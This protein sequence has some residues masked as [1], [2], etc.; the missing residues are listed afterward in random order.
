MCFLILHDTSC[1]YVRMS[2][3]II[4]CLLLCSHHM[5]MMA[6]EKAHMNA[7]INHFA[8]FGICSFISNKKVEQRISGSSWSLCPSFPYDMTIVNICQPI[9]LSLSIP[10]NHCWDFC[11]CRL[12]LSYP[13]IQIIKPGSLRDCVHASPTSSLLSLSLDLHFKYTHL[14]CTFSRLVVWFYV[15]LHILQH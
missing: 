1:A 8:P 5:G 14:Q 7:Q 15:L 3:G 4:Q 6:R 11:S 13:L 9:S 10:T 12:N 2:R